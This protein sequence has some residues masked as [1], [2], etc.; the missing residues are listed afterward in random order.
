MENPLGEEEVSIQPLNSEQNINNGNVA[1][2]PSVNNNYGFVPLPNGGTHIDPRKNNLENE[3]QNDDSESGDESD[4]GD[5]SGQEKY[6]KRKFQS[7]EEYKAAEYWKEQINL[8]MGRYPG[9]EP[10][11]SHTLLARLDQF[12]LRDLRTIYQNLINDVYQ[13]RGT[14][15]AN[16]LLAVLTRPVDNHYKGFTARCLQDY[17]LKKDIET[18]LMRVFGFLSTRFCIIIRLLNNLYDTIFDIN[19]NAIDPTLSPPELT[20]GSSNLVNNENL[21]QQEKN[22]ETYIEPIG[23]PIKRRRRLART[24]RDRED[25]SDSSDST[26]DGFLLQQQKGQSAS[27]FIFNSPSF[28]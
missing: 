5:L 12:D 14:P 7:V 21:Q 11:T 24:R 6:K 2:N 20:R 28:S 8:I 16:V 27:S 9:L 23:R 13:F 4:F 3:R 19:F 22:K 18:E 15:S 10:R 26:D 25:Q 1:T 17:E